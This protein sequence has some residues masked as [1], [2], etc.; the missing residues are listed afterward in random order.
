MHYLTTVHIR[1]SGISFSIK[2]IILFK[3]RKVALANSNCTGAKKLKMSRWGGEGGGEAGVQCSSKL[4]DVGCLVF[5]SWRYSPAS[6]INILYLVRDS[7]LWRLVLLLTAVCWSVTY[8]R[9]SYPAS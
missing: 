3:A 4:I 8:C 7:L 2:P 6:L 1:N 5:S 9:Y